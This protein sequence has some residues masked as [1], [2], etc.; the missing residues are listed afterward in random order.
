M[1][2]CRQMDGTGEREGGRKRKMDLADDQG[3][4][5]EKITVKNPSPSITPISSS[6][7]FPPLALPFIDSASTYCT[8]NQLRPGLACSTRA[9]RP[10]AAGQAALVP[11]N[12]VQS[13]LALRPCLPRRSVVMI[14]F[15]CDALPPGASPTSAEQGSL[16]LQRESEESGKRDEG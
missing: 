9:M 10:A 7:L 15:P 5:I 12:V 3:I 14:F 6:L 1:R 13:E 11:A 8:S 2:V 16:Y 4:N